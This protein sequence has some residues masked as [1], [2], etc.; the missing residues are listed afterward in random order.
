M[1]VPAL[2]PLIACWP[3][4]T[5]SARSQDEQLGTQL[6]DEAMAVLESE[7]F[8]CHGGTGKLK[9]GL[10]LSNRAD[11]LDGGQSGA[12]IDGQQADQ[13][14]LLRMIRWSDDHHQM[15]PTGKLPQQQLAALERWVDAGVPY[16]SDR[17]ASEGPIEDAASAGRSDGMDGWSY[18][19]LRAP[20]TPAVSRRD[21][22][23]SPLDAFL[24]SRLEGAGLVP[25]GPADR[26]TLIRRATYDL[27]GLPPTA[28]QL[29]AFV[30]DPREDAYERLIDRLLSS[31]HYGERWG[32]HWLDL[33]R[34]AETNGY[35]RDSNKPEIWKYRDYV[36]RS[37][38][39]DKPYDRFLIEQIAGD[40]LDEPTPDSITATG[41]YR[42]M[43][44]DD[45]PGAGALQARYD[46]LDDITRTT[47]ET[48]LGM[49]LGCARCHDHKGDP[50]PQ[51]DYY[52]FVAFFH[53]LTDMSTNNY[54]SDIM[55]DAERAEHDAAVAA[56]DRE[57]D[58]LAA[59]LRSFEDRF[60]AALAARDAAE[61]PALVSDLSD[62]RYRFYR[63]TWDRLP[64]FDTL[65]AEDEGTLEAGLIDLS[66]ATRNESIGFVYEG[67][68]LVPADDEYTFALAAE[69]GARL[70]IGD[71]VVIDHDGI[72]PLQQVKEGHVPL[73]RG[74]VPLRVDYLHRN[75]RPG[76][77]LS[78]RPRRAES[79]RYTVEEP[80]ETWIEPDFDER[81]W[82]EGHGGFGSP[83]TPGS[84]VG[85]PWHEPQIWLRRE[86]EW[87]AGAADELMLAVHHDEDVTVSINGVRA[88]HRGG[89][90]GDY[91]TFDITDE[92]RA[93]LRD[94][95]NQLAVHCRQT[96]GG[97]FIHVV[98]VTRSQSIG[99]RPV[100]VAFGQRPLS[101]GRQRDAAK[102]HELV[103]RRGL[104]VLA[105]REV[106]NYRE[107]R[108][109]LDQVKRRRIVPPRAPAVQE[110]GPT[111]ADMHVHIR[112]NAHT[113]GDKVE[114]GFPTCIDPSPPVFPEPAS[115]ARSSG[116]RRVLAE[117]MVRPD[118]PLTA[119]VMVNR[120]WQHHFGRPL[121]PTPSDFGELGM[122]PTHPEL[123]D[124]L[125]TEFISSGWSMK[126]MHRSLMTS[127]AYRMASTPTRAGLELDPANELY[128][129]FDMRRL[130][131]EEVRDSILSL[132]GLLNAKMFGPSFYSMM[133]EAAL[134]TSSRP[135]SVWGK[136]P[137]RE[138]RR[139]SVYIKVKRSLV[140]PMLS[141][142]DL[143]DT[144][145]SC[146]V[147]FAT[148]QPQ[149]ALA[150]LNG[151]FAQ[152]YAAEF[153]ARLRQ[154]AGDD[155]EAQV[156]RA[157]QIALSRDP[158]PD[159]V[160]RHLAL[161]H[162]LRTEEGLDADRALRSYCLTVMNLSEFLYLD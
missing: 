80:A 130:G 155:P 69:G 158:R 49:T 61:R 56:R 35:E 24:L 14:L 110:R 28:A 144:D 150:L 40:E 146:P 107:L 39:Q 153:A 37:F 149:Q 151:D 20:P 160:A 148:T 114:P 108:K 81:G 113:R 93:A 127:S 57:R 126:S 63:D 143:A 23:R 152:K 4:L 71:H 162:E 50:I 89:Y 72:H 65:R 8:R 62:L 139:R 87:S 45:E 70:R 21:W 3:G 103:D 115:G 112:G 73:T 123:L 27:T 47:S 25:A 117:W 19:P 38:Q 43:I 118:N 128:W 159:E 53:N 64:E 59:E 122:R 54:F 76:L 82:Q 9:G 136:S 42:L 13:S 55:N 7:C 31:P 111:V 11:L 75:G 10:R 22:I 34:Y 90:R 147:R 101:V 124:W 94:G 102:V 125:A 134:A 48:F 145:Q 105:E 133:P 116:R 77:N 2:L 135:D 96:G 17:L 92:A 78:W 29:K 121:V 66:P 12:V 95:T 100:D 18:R 83:G 36:I 44:W 141:S 74:L 51:E 97:Q 161:I 60:L 15:P 52:R 41:F 79:W 120:I 58:G 131:A 67:S 6:V 85:T 140:V 91:E 46:V 106:Q 16:P 138:A 68:L 30:E 132:S 129:R 84:I 142:F 154:E 88:F 86:F 99:R 119:R 109:R 156:R 104:E 1:R 32:R 26:R 33:V 5:A 137:D 98:P 157:L